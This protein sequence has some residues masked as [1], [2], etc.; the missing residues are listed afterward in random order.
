MRYAF[1]IDGTICENINGNYE[2]AKPYP[3]MI[4]LINSLYDNGDYII[5]HTARGM[6]RFGGNKALAM[7]Q[8]YCL[9]KMQLDDWGVKYHELHLGKILADV[10]IDDRGFRIKADGSSVEDLQN[11]LKGDVTPEDGKA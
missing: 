4:K 2:D 5:F 6:G 3:E 10:Y 8:W 9:T 7:K 1:D 11:F